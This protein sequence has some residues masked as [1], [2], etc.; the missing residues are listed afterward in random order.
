MQPKVKEIYILDVLPSMDLCNI[1]LEFSYIF[2][3]VEFILFLGEQNFFK[4]DLYL[5]TTD[6]CLRLHVWL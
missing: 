6:K 3:N 2:V 4:I 5:H 1:C